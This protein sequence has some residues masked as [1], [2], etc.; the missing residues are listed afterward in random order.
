MLPVER[1]WN[2][3]KS[4]IVDSEPVVLSPEGGRW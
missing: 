3:F 1:C 2:L 4:E